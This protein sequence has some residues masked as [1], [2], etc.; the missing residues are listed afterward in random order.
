MTE[1]NE[2]FEANVLADPAIMGALKDAQ[3]YP[4]RAHKRQRKETMSNEEFLARANELLDDEDAERP[5]DDLAFGA[6][7]TEPYTFYPREE[8]ESDAEYQRRCVFEAI[9]AGSTC[10]ESL[11]G[12]GIFQDDRAVAVGNALCEVLGLPGYA[13]RT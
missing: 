11:E 2:E 13:V 5:R 8:Q 4:E 6:T 9:G 12:T 3:D 7:A 10:W 1:T